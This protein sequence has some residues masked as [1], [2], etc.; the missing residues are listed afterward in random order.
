MNLG[1][2][3]EDVAT[4]AWCSRERASGRGAAAALTARARQ[5][6]PVEP[7]FARGAQEPVAAGQHHVAVRRDE[8]QA[9]AGAAQ[10]V[11][12]RAR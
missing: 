10:H 6:G 7:A 2:A 11:A 4:A 9:Q 12:A 3:V 8:L 1:V 5:P